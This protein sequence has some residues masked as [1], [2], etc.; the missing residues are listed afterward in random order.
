MEIINGIRI[1]QFDFDVD[2]VIAEIKWRCMDSGMNY[3]AF[4][5]GGEKDSK[6]GNY[7]NEDKDAKFL[8]IAKYLKDNKIY[9]SFTNSG[10][11]CCFGLEKETFSEIKKIAGNYYI[12]N[13]ICEPGGIWCNGKDYGVKNFEGNLQEAKDGFVDYI[14]GLI[15]DTQLPD[16]LKSEVGFIEALPLLTY[17]GESNAVFPI[18]ETM[19]GNPEIMVPMVRGT[20][21]AHNKERFMT[22]IAHEYYGG[23][24]WE[25]TLKAKRLRMVYNYAYLCGS[26]G[27]VLE[28]GDLGY[29]IIRTEYGNYRNP[30]GEVFNHPVARNYRETLREFAD[31]MNHDVRPEGGPKV[32]FA[33]VQ[34]NLDGWSSF[35]PGSAVWDKF[36]DPAYGYSGPEYTWRIMD[37]INVRRSWCEV[38]NYGDIDLS[39]APAYG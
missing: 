19:P 15:A 17:I 16:E 14:N 18:V 22:Y 35:S 7:K 8:T 20:A 31:F 26:M 38:H 4:S 23:L 34:G 25:D 32:K 1:G 2:R 21:K 30:N 6:W 9:F 36:D 27:F 3:V 24:R 39:G 12:G 33:F 10:G 5:A 28:S 37:D 13:F 29:R 11:R